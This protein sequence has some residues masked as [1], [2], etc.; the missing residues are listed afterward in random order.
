MTLNY[1][2]KGS[3]SSRTTV[4]NIEVKGHY[5]SDIQTRSGPTALKQSVTTKPCIRG[6]TVR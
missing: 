1:E 4:P 2:F 6:R 5:C 3:G